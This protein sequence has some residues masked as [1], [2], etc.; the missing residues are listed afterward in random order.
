MS[1][2]FV[3]IGAGLANLSLLY[4]MQASEYFKSKSIAIVEPDSK[5]KNDRTWCFWSTQNPIYEKAVQKQWS[6]MSFKRNDQRWTQNINPYQ[7]YYIQ[8]SDFY[9][10]VISS[11]K[12]D[13]NIDWYR[14]SV[15]D[16]SLRS[17]NNT[18]Y[19]ESG[20]ELIGHYVF[21]SSWQHSGN[22]MDRAGMKQHFFGIKLKLKENNLS[23][24][25]VHLMDFSFNTDKQSVQFG[26]I[27]P[28]NGNEALIEYTEFSKFIKSKSEYLQILNT[29][30]K[31]LGI[32]D[33]ELIDQEF[34]VIPMSK[35]H[36]NDRRSD[37]FINT[38]TVGGLTKP[39]TGYTFQFVQ[40]DSELIINC[41]KEKRVIPVRGRGSRFK[42]YDSLLLSIV[43]KEPWTVGPIMQ[44]LF[45]RNKFIKILKFLDEES[46]LMEEIRIFVSL[47]WKPFLK[48]LI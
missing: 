35:N 32:S 15:K 27:L 13:L 47:P 19:L 29:Y 1:Y 38:G 9:Q 41:L 2:D 5:T 31:N 10:E 11:I 42:F 25:S 48:Q 24:D 28:I 18:L 20:E 23:F 14:T 12:V 26:Y 44:K 6:E 45:S 4:R 8:G 7:Y 16:V 33:Y 40:K 30:I 21:N 36:F 46:S 39:T 17:N 37:Y 43:E 3:F 22:T 34:G